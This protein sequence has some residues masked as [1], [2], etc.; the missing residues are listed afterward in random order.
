MALITAERLHRWKCLFCGSKDKNI[1]SV[2]L[3]LNES[4]TTS[5]D[6][7]NYAEGVK[8]VTCSQCGKTEIFSHSALAM[9]GVLT[10][11]TVTIEESEEFVNKFHEMNHIDPKIN[12][13]ATHGPKIGK[14]S[15]LS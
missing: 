3:P 11:K 12:P 2:K 15:I 1:M 4:V 7:E 8:I 6:P 9:M 13:H 14:S 5:T 10:G